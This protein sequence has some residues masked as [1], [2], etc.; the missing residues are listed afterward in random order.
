MSTRHDRLA[1]R[2][3]ASPQS[4]IT[5]ATLRPEGIRIHPIGL[6][7]SL[8][9]IVTNAPCAIAMLD[10]GF[11]HL[12]V[13]DTYCRELRTNKV[14][15]L[16]R[17][18]K[19]IFPVLPQSWEASLQSCLAGESVTSED[20]WSCSNDGQQF[21][22]N[23]QLD[24]WKK[25]RSKIGGTIL[26]LKEPNQNSGSE[27]LH[28]L[29]LQIEHAK[30]METVCSISRGIAHDL[31]DMLLVINGYSSLLMEQLGTDAILGA[32]ATSIHRAGQRV[33]RL[34]EQLLALSRF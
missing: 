9:A 25:S 12:A 28:V 14:A 23:C 13:S 15:I 17:T 30:K 19:E 7:N 24:P 32:E 33:A 27:N 3:I 26:F 10:D 34:A 4:R 18:H 8:E 29:D 6:Q 20:E 31:N 2:T 16:H 1:S 21:R 5:L 22:V 11:R